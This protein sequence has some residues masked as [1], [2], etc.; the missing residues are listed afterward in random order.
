MTSNVF[1]YCRSYSELLTI[2][3]ADESVVNVMQQ[4]PYLLML[5]V[6]ETDNSV[7]LLGATWTRSQEV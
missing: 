2:I 7:K 4:H 6:S 1:M 3:D 5:A